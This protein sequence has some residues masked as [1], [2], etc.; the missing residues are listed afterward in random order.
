MNPA[1]TKYAAR[2][3]AQMYGNV[4]AVVAKGAVQLRSESSLSGF[5]CYTL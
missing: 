5:P 3:Q 4:L 2:Q 1:I